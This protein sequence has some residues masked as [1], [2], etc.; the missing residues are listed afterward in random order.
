MISNYNR[1]NQC[2]YV[3]RGMSTSSVGGDS[4]KINFARSLEKHILKK[5]QIFFQ[6]A[7]M[8]SKSKTKYTANFWDQICFF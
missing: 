6:F 8:Y 4:F 1:H 2:I 7:P 5:E 3:L